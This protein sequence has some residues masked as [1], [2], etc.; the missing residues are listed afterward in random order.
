[1]KRILICGSNGLL[2]QRL[3]LL[4][5][6]QTEYEV[7]NTS[8]HRSFVLNK[9]LFDYTQLDIAN[10]SD[11]KSLV[12]SFR[13]DIIINPA[14]MTNVDECEIQ[15]ENAWKINV[16]GVENLVEAARRT[17]AKLI[18]ISTDYVFDGKNG[19]YKEEDKP[20]P[21]NYYGR[22]KLAGENAIITSEI[23]F[24]IIRTIVVYGVGVNVKN[25]FALWVYNSLQSGKN[26]SC[27][28]DQNSNPTYVGDLANGIV[29]CVEH[30]GEGIFHI[31][32][33]EKVS[34]YD[35][36]VSIAKYFQLDSSL[37]KKIKT[38]ELPQRAERPMVT[39]F[40]TTKAEKILHHKP[41]NVKEGIEAMKKDMEYL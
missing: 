24:S 27:V 30:N 16:I 37:I 10:R 35:F 19:P 11:V 17:G 22:T 2:G 4:F 32:G 36:A 18:H 20:N 7:L 6:Y 41:M 34:R 15:R 5:G 31:C 39:G 29:K 40:I 3:A 28:D 23:P 14:A 13:P 9:H 21:I 38:S 25:N 1:M 26:I 8:H 12:S 33:A